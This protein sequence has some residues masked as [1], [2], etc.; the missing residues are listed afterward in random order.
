MGNHDKSA[1]F[2]LDSLFLCIS[3]D[4]ENFRAAMKAMP[5]NIDAAE[6][7][8][9]SGQVDQAVGF[10][11]THCH[12][13]IHYHQFVGTQLGL[14]YRRL[15]GAR[16][17]LR[18]F[19]LQDIGAQRYQA[20]VSEGPRRQAILEVNG[21]YLFSIHPGIRKYADP[22][23]VEML[24]WLELF[25]AYLFEG[26]CADLFRSASRVR[27]IL[28]ACA[29]ITRIHGIIDLGQVLEQLANATPHDSAPTVRDGALFPICE[30]Q[31][32]LNEFA[33]HR[34][35]PE[36]AMEAKRQKWFGGRYWDIA[37]RFG[38]H[39][40]GELDEQIRVSAAVLLAT[41]IALDG[42]LS[43]SLHDVEVGQ[44][45]LHPMEMI[46]ALVTSYDDWREV[47]DGPFEHWG[48]EDFLARRARA[49]AAAVKVG[50]LTVF[51][52]PA[53]DPLQ[54]DA[55][56]EHPFIQY[57]GMFAGLG[58]KVAQIRGTD[59][60]A[61]LFPV[62]AIRERPETFTGES[63]L[64]QGL[65]CPFLSIGDTPFQNSLNEE[66]WTRW[67]LLSG[68]EIWL[69]NLFC[70]NGNDFSHLPG[71]PKLI[72][73]ISTIAKQRIEGVSDARRK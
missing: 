67:R 45:A 16:A 70:G 13:F 5:R 17:R 4:A 30:A 20:L 2:H 71:N 66:I 39:P 18:E 55:R 53:G 22:S 19:F 35:G 21:P 6:V 14:I 51:D 41:D 64:L 33:L 73:T 1:V 31:A 54:S 59:P 61:A 11:I 63:E 25:D 24:G 38:W 32:T 28:E 50:N 37:K 29:S 62:A 47:L 46:D 15:V 58:D 12:E 43:P 69:D 3:E 42:I 10:L 65:I 72:T 60:T 48:R 49:V 26:K 36:N 44:I 23:I 27:I 7:A 57:L 8:I 52:I 68:Y 34:Y 9:R 56:D 40:S